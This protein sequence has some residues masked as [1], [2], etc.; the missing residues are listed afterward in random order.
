MS[1]LPLPALHCVH[2]MCLANLATHMA[3]Y[4]S[5]QGARRWMSDAF[6]LATDRNNDRVFVIGTESAQQQVEKL[7]KHMDSLKAAMERT[8]RSIHSC[9]NQGLAISLPQPVQ[10]MLAANA[11][12]NQLEASK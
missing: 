12:L 2:S 6:G 3:V 4:K 5:M 1:T 11:Q 8:T 7:Q 9:Q 10:V